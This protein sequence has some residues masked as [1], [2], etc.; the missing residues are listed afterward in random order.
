MAETFQRVRQ[1]FSCPTPFSSLMMRPNISSSAIEDTEAILLCPV[2]ATCLSLVSGSLTTSTSANRTCTSGASSAPQ[3]PASAAAV[4]PGTKQRRMGQR[5]AGATSASAADASSSSAASAGSNTGGSS[6]SSAGGIAEHGEEVDEDDTLRS[7][8][9]APAVATAPVVPNE[10]PGLLKGIDAPGGGTSSGAP[11][12]VAAAGSAGPSSTPSQTV[13]DSSAAGAGAGAGT[14]AA[15]TASTGSSKAEPN[16]R[17]VSSSPGPSS[18]PQGFSPMAHGATASSATAAAAA[19][20]RPAGSSSSPSG[21]CFRQHGREA[22]HDVDEQDGMHNL[23]PQHPN[24]LSTPTSSMASPGPRMA[25]LNKGGLPTPAVPHVRMISP[26][27]NAPRETAAAQGP[28]LMW[29]A[30]LPIAR[31]G[32]VN[33]EGANFDR[34]Q[35]PCCTLCGGSCCAKDSEHIWSWARGSATKAAL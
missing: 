11:S 12:P 30:S 22:A 14:R 19:P 16:N 32:K 4:T 1:D 25:T 33:C 15:A 10:P 21:A 29:L 13:D 5:R 18:K 31:P 9:M 3:R 35:A 20:P 26:R 24:Q 34:L 8:H 27:G 28:S 17:S 7:A 23:G 2:I 6:S